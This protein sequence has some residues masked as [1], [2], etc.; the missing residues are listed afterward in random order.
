MKK[1]FFPRKK[2]QKEAVIKSLDGFTQSEINLT[3]SIGAGRLT[4]SWPESTFAEIIIPDMAHAV[5]K[6]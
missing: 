5:R 1:S 2:E 6:G 4:T 3:E